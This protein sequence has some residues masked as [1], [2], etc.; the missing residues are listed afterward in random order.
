MWERNADS[1]RSDCALV[2]AKIG[3]STA[4]QSDY[5]S[6]IEQPV[7]WGAGCGGVVCRDRFAGCDRKH[8]SLSTTLP[9]KMGTEI[10]GLIPC[11]HCCLLSE[12]RSLLRGL[13]LCLA[14]RANRRR[15]L[16]CLCSVWV[17]FA[18]CYCNW[19]YPAWALGFGPLSIRLFTCRRVDNRHS[20]G[21][22][23]LFFFDP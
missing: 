14:N 9:R 12:L 1:N 3:F 13:I 6:R 17:V 15:C 22:R 7:H 23:C 2:G 21:L 4:T 10:L 18:I 19:L 20:A 8:S 11:R 16:P 5:R